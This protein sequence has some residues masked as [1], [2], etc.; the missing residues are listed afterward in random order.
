M[1]LKTV[2]DRVLT[3]EG[4]L[5][6]VSDASVSYGDYHRVS[7]GN[8]ELSLKITG[9]EHA[10]RLALEGLLDELKLFLDSR[11]QQ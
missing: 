3:I 4:S 1:E 9:S 5:D 2:T 7:Y 8:W 10:A 6:R 11:K